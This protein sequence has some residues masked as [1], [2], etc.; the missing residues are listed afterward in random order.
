[1][2]GFPWDFQHHFSTNEKSK[3]EGWGRQEA[4]IRE[5]NNKERGAGCTALKTK[6]VGS[7]GKVV[8]EV[9]LSKHGEGQIIGANREEKGAN[10]PRES[11]RERKD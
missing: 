5:G 1:M 9:T 11:H 7:K 8:D 10:Q 2:E 6:G 4:E 3:E